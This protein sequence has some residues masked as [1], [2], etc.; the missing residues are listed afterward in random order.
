[1]WKVTVK[2]LLAHKLRLA[3]TA[4]AIVLGVTF[5]SG[6]FVL[7]D[8]LHNTFTTLFGHIYQNVDFEVRGTAAFSGNNG[9]AVRKPIPESIAPAVRTL[10]VS[11]TPR[12]PSPVTRSSSHRTGRRSP[13]AERPPSASPTIPTQQLSPLRLAS[14]SA[15]TTPHQVVMDEGTATKYHFVVGDHVRIL[16]AGPTADVHHLRHRHSSGRPTTWPVPPWRR[17]ICRPLRLVRPGRAVRCHQRRDHSRGPTRPPSQRSIAAVLPA[18][19]EVVTGQTVADEQTNSIDQAL[20]FFSTAPA[21]LRVHLPVRRRVHHLQHVLDHRRAADPGT[22]PAA[23]RRRQPPSGVPVGARRGG[24]RR[25]GRVTDRPGARACW[26]RSGS[27]RCSRDSGSRCRPDRWCS[28]RAPW[29]WAWWSGSGVTVVSA[30]SPARRAVRIPPVAALT[31]HRTDAASRRGGGSSSAAVVAAGRS[32]SCWS[33]GWP[34]RPSRWSGVGAVGI[35]IG[36]AM[37]APVVARPIVQRDRAAAGRGCS[38]PGSWAGRT[39]CAAPGARPRPPSALM[40]GLALVSAIAVFGAS[41]SKSATSSV[42]QAISADLIVTSSGTGP[43][44]SAI[45]AGRRRRGARRHRGVNRVQRAV[46]VPELARRPHGGVHR[47]PGQHGDPADGRGHG[48][49]AL[50]AGNCSSTPPRRTPS[51]CRWAGRCR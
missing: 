47:R 30:I 23:D 5:I 1:M 6:T 8:T 32:R 35:F 43:G 24:H 36:V 40:V 3:L 13:P 20:S 28:S 38:A 48:A 49:A 9:N 27:R 44:G 26:P 18:G 33:S 46:R 37:L 21:G 34:S 15:P 29:S 19:V 31:D 50:A 12:G 4:L 7:T 17:S 41:L 51:T 42:D 10:P 14:G 22:G 45:G 2:G 11:P 16:L 39:R 25:A